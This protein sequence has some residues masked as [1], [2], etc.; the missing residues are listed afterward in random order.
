MER[1]E[2]LKDLTEPER[3][4]V[5]NMHPSSERG[6]E[7]QILPHPPANR[8]FEQLARPQPNPQFQT[9]TTHRPLSQV[10]YPQKQPPRLNPVK[11]MSEPKT[12][13]ED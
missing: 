8:Q 6:A 12:A 5:S 3:A 9:G 10:T 4:T 2:E 7:H 13:H 11:F 1:P